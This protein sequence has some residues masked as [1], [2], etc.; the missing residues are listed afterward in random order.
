MLV[1]AHG[2]LSTQHRDTLADAAK[3]F[4]TRHKEWA[5]DV[6]PAAAA[7][8]LTAGASVDP[9]TRNAQRQDMQLTGA[10]AL[11]LKVEPEL[12]LPKYRSPGMERGSP[13]NSAP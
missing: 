6:V 11:S 9:C 8:R 10:S 12:L 2:P 4:L 3:A 1:C 13:T 7:A 5:H